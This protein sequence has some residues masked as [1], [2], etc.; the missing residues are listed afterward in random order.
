ME[1]QSRILVLSAEGNS[2]LSRACLNLA[3]YI[4][5]NSGVNLDDLQYTLAMKNSGYLTKHGV[6]STD[7]D[8]TIRRLQNAAASVR[9]NKEES[10][11]QRSTVFVFPGQGVQYAGMGAMLYKEEPVFKEVVDYCANRLETILG[12]DIRDLMFCT[13]EGEQDANERLRQTAI[14][15]PAIFIIEYALAKVWQSYGI[16]PSAMIGH[17]IGQYA[18]A[19][20]SGVFSLDDCLLLVS[21]R[22]RVIQEMAPGLMLSVP[23]SASKLE[24][25]LGTHLSLASVNAPDLCVASGP[26][27]LVEQLQKD[28]ADE[29]IVSK[30]LKTSHAFHSD[31]M[32][33]ATESF[34]KVAEE[35]S[36]NM[37]KIPFICTSVGTWITDEQAT[38]AI[39]WAD[40]IRRAVLFSPGVNTLLKDGT[41]LFLEMGPRNTM[42]TLVRRHFDPPGNHVAISSMGRPTDNEHEFFANALGQ[43]VRSGCEIDILRNINRNKAQVLSLPDLYSGATEFEATPEE[44]RILTLEQQFLIGVWRELLNVER[45]DIDDD[46]F[47]LGG[48]SLVG[49]QLIDR[50]TDRFSVKLLLSDII[51][52]PTVRALST[53]IVEYA[54]SGAEGSAVPQGTPSRQWSPLVGLK[55]DGEFPPLFCVSGIG[56]HV[57]EL[58]QLAEGLKGIPF[59]G[60]ET[61]GVVEG[62]KPHDTIEA[63]ASEHVSAIMA[64]QANGPYFL[65]GYSIGGMVAFEMAKQL[66]EKGEEIAWLGLIDTYSP[67]LR[68]REGLEFRIVQLKRFLHDPVSYVRWAIQ[69]RR[70]KRDESPSDRYA[71]I[72]ETML[73]A[74]TNYHPTSFEGDA[75]LFQTKKSDL[76]DDIQWSI[77]R[78]NGWRPLVLGNIEVIPV[79][80]RHLTVVQEEENVRCISQ[81]MRASILAHIP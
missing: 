76:I 26:A 68:K 78:Y 8:A 51:Q 3:D 13:G 66:V 4:A 56:G 36:M 62:H 80:G 24:A 29:G 9:K 31:M 41:R 69:R 35:V 71:A 20:L 67:V 43:A 73:R 45:V 61:R 27:A 50:I 63:L 17:S 70:Q 44:E 28:L 14:T 49:I 48:H 16:Q 47:D 79:L 30:L 46:F 52:N 59:Y 81:K 21:E 2:E 40:Q 11:L 38:S 22:G 19:C 58:K 33:D 10:N 15:Q 32:V 34:R 37:P 74:R 5:L 18:A 54:Q 23:L 77:D 53:V 6:L 12:F 60:L 72:Y 42:T 65:C 1:K 64:I 7:S 55:T 57:M 25:R 75:V 39:H